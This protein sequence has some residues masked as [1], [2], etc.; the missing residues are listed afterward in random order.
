MNDIALEHVNKWLNLKQRQNLR[1]ALL[2]YSEG[3]CS[4]ADVLLMVAKI[5][6]AG[7]MAGQIMGAA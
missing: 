1:K 6:E 5:A 4:D 7:F 3:K 2:E